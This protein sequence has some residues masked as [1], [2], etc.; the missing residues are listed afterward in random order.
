MGGDADHKLYLPLVGRLIGAQ[1]VL[2]NPSFEEGWYHPDGISELQ[3]PNGWQFNWLDENDP[4]LD[5][6]PWN[7]WVRPEARVLASAFLPEEERPLFIW[8]GNQTVKIFKGNGAI[9]FELTTILNLSPGTYTLEIYVFPDLVVYY[10]NG[11]KVWAPDPLSGEVRL[12]AGGDGTDWLLPTFGQRN[13]FEHTFTVMQAR[14]VHV[15]AAMRGRWAIQN[16]GWFMDNWAL[17]QH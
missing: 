17:Y 3:I 7:K 4:P 8:D 2:P 16:N 11:E 12:I 1:N 5:P 6:D 9:S 10:E 14:P 15:G 13:R